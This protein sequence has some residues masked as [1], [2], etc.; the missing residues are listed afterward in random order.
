MAIV[1]H[2]FL[3]FVRPYSSIMDRVK[4]KGDLI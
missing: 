2:S 1:P 4:V 3:I